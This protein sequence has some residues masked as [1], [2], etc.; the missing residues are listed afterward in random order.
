MTW[1]MKLPLRK[2]LKIDIPYMRFGN[3]KKQIHKRKNKLRNIVQ[4]SENWWKFLSDTVQRVGR[5]RQ[6]GECL[7]FHCQSNLIRAR[8][9]FSESEWT[10]R[11]H[12][13]YRGSANEIKQPI[14]QF[15]CQHTRQRTQDVPRQTIHPIFFL[16]LSL[17]TILAP[18]NALIQ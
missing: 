12:Y 14:D 11:A 17:T 4:Q 1:Q 9:K 7:I 10:N 16:P 13:G 8:L 5:G 2:N 3:T 18:N 6:R 15:A